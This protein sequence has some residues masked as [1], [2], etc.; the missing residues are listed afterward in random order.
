[1]SLISYSPDDVG[2]HIINKRG[3]IIKIRKYHM[4]EEE[5]KKTRRKWLLDVK[6]VDRRIRKKAGRLFFNPY[7]RGI[8]YYQIQALFLLGANQWHGLS[9]IL[10]KIEDIMSTVPERGIFSNAWEKFKG[11]SE[12]DNALRCKDYIGRIQENFILLQR[13]TGRH[14]YGYKLKQ[15]CVAIDTKRVSKRG[16]PNGIY[17]YRLS[18]YYSTKKALPLRD[19]KKFK[20]PRHEKKYISSRFIGTVITKNKIIKKGVVV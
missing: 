2:K 5:M 7:R 17:Y 13:L 18:T 6:E 1:M 20:F 10:K 15:V 3:K 8:Y 11:K 12:R 9:N 14:P 16:M 4:I 19:Y